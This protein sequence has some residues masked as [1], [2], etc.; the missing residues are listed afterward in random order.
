M[1]SPGVAGVLGVLGVG[2]SSTQGTTPTTEQASDGAGGCGSP[3]DGTEGQPGRLRSQALFLSGVLVEE[4]LL[5]PESEDPFDEVDVSLFDD[6]VPLDVLEELPSPDE[7]AS[8]D[9]PDEPPPEPELDGASLGALSDE[10]D[11]PLLLVA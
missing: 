8:P 4:E 1:P 2:G 5:D 9:E 11:G 7:L 10:P 6:L 3:S